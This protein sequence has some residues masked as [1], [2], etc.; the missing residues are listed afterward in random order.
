MIASMKPLATALR[1]KGPSALLKRA[2]LIAKRYGLTVTKMERSLG[3]LLQLLQEFDCQATL[4]VTAVALARNRPLFREFQARG[5]E[6]AV[7]GYTHVDYSRLAPED[8]LAHL[9]RA[10]ELFA[11]AGVAGVGFRSPY[12][13]RDAHLHRALEAAGFAYVSNHPIVWDVLDTKGFSETAQAAYER[14]VEFYEPWHAS[15]RLSIPQLHGRL[16]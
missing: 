16:V 2:N 3:M 14:A 9:R 7:H 1:A 4:P 11:E 15:E 13:S 6:F 5:I 8:Q 10:R 12:L